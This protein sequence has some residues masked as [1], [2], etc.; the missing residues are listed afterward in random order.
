MTDAPTILIDILDYQPAGG[1]MICRR[2]A[3][4]PLPKAGAALLRWLRAAHE[5][6]GTHGLRFHVLFAARACNGAPAP[7]PTSA[8]PRANSIFRLRTRARKRTTSGNCRKAVAD[9]ILNNGDGAAC[10]DAK[11]SLLIGKPY[12]AAPRS[13]TLA[14]AAFFFNA[15]TS[16]TDTVNPPPQKQRLSKRVW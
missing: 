12:L 9:P 8:A 3:C 11:A 7:F 13:W 14:G 1:L 6:D 4:G 15:T 10:K 5:G 16:R 2:P